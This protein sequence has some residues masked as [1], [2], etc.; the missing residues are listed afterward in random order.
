LYATSVLVAQDSNNNRL[1]MLAH[2]ASSEADIVVAKYL[3]LL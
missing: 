2:G 1:A 3:G